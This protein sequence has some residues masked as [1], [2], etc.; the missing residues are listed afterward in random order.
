MPQGK[1]A[2]IISR[3]KRPLFCNACKHSGAPS[4]APRL[5]TVEGR[6]MSEEIHFLNDQENHLLESAKEAAKS[7]R[8]TMCFIIIS[9][10]IL[11]ITYRAIKAPDWVANRIMHYEKALFCWN[12]NNVEKD[13]DNCQESVRYTIRHI[14]PRANDPKG[15]QSDEYLKD[16]KP[17]KEYKDEIFENIKYLRKKRID[18]RTIQIPIIGLTL[19]PRNLGFVASIILTILSIILYVNIVREHRICMLILRTEDRDRE[20]R[21]EIYPI[22]YASQIFLNKGLQVFAT[23]VMGLPAL[24]VTLIFVFQF[25]SV[26]QDGRLFFW[27]KYESC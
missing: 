9:L 23:I 16:F 8:V 21:N 20:A 19:S 27:T 10:F 14:T 1:Q 4:A 24:C 13:F 11:G 22:I 18:L 12:S 25:S 6:L 5:H 15:K 26:M 17:E 2:Q 7:T 3:A